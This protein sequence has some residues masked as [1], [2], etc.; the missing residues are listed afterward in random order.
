MQ[1]KV[2]LSHAELFYSKETMSVLRLFSSLATFSLKKITV[3][4]GLCVA[5]EMIQYGIVFVGSVHCL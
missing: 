4:E 5:M 2:R 1:S 3:I